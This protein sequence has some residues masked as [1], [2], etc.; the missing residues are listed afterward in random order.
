MRSSRAMNARDGLDADA[1]GSP[2]QVGEELLRRRGLGPAGGDDQEVAREGDPDP[3]PA[4]WRRSA[5]VRSGSAPARPRHHRPAADR[6]R[7]ASSQRPGLRHPAG[8]A[9][10]QGASPDPRRGAGGARAGCSCASRAAARSLRVGQG[11]TGEAPRDPGQGIRLGRLQAMLLDEPAD[12]LGPRHGPDAERLAAGADGGQELARSRPRQGRRHVGRPVPP[13]ALSRAFWI[14]SPARSAPSMRTTRR[15]PAIGAPAASASQRRAT[16][17]TDSP[18]PRSS[19]QRSGEP[20]TRS[21]WLRDRAPRQPAQALHGRSVP[22]G[23]AQKSSARRSS[24]KAP[25][26]APAGPCTRKVR[27][28]R[29]PAAARRAMVREV[30][31]PRL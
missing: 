17:T 7:T 30:C 15:L 29:W 23:A 27:P 4:R 3:R 19:R 21:G 31:W 26:P 12:Q 6:R 18:V 1:P 11:A 5:G 20:R 24:T 13:G 16:A 25:L 22:G 2:G 14:G 8:H 10:I 9:P 28:S